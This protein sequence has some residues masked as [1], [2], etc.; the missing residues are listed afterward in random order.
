MAGTTPNRSYPYP[1][2]ADTPDGAA[3]IQSLA[4]AVDT[5]VSKL[6]IDNDGYVQGAYKTVALSNVTWAAESVTFPQPYK[7]G[8]VPAVV[9]TAFADGDLGGPFVASVYN[10]TETGFQLAAGTRDSSTVTRTVQCWWMAVGE[11]A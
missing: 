1:E 6:N 5:D 2:P 9:A 10:I 7:A 4:D 11:K 8:N 3:Q